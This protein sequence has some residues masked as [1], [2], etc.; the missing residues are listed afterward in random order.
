MAA[1]DEYV[2]SE[3][4]DY[5]IDE[6]EKQLRE[7]GNECEGSAVIEIHLGDVEDEIRRRCLDRGNFLEG[8]LGS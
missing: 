7:I 8:N 2:D 5:F 4:P 6:C 1:V 3:N